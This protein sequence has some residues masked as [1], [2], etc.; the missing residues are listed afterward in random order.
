MAPRPMPAFL[1]SADL[2]AR[3]I[4]GLVPCPMAG[5]PRRAS[6]VAMPI[7]CAAKRTASEATMT[8][9][10]PQKGILDIEPYVGGRAGATGAT[11]VFK[12]SANE[13]PLGASPR[14]R[15]AFLS[16]AESMALYPDGGADEL[17]AVIAARYGLNAE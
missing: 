3:T 1:R 14:A 4:R 8:R 12:L 15:D 16:A 11:K 9:P 10:T 5:P 13:T 17:R 7:R 6:S 2:S